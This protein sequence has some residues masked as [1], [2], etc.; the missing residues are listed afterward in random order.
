MEQ[1]LLRLIELLRR[2]S[3]RFSVNPMFTLQSGNQSPFY[4]DCKPTYLDPEGKELIGSIMFEYV[5]GRGI[6]AIG[7]MEIGSLP[8]SGAVSLISQLRGEP[9][10]DFFVRKKV[11]DHGTAAKV[12]GE[13]KSGMKV[14]VVDDVVTTGASTIKAIEAVQEIGAVVVLVLLIV[15][16]QEYNGRESIQKAA[17]DA[18]VV[19]LLLRDQVMTEEEKKQTVSKG[20][21]K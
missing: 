5:R 20:R 14:A 2:K 17:P 16:R 9:I 21:E 8:I 15:D 18:E 10:K 6:E 13:I 1:R 12:E 3:F 4:F 7:G 11:K 19:S